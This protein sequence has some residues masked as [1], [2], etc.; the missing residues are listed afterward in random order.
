MITTNKTPLYNIPWAEPS[1]MV[2]CTTTSSDAPL[3]ISTLPDNVLSLSATE[4]C[5]SD[6]DTLIS[7]DRDKLKLI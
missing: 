6:N 5:G 3:F 1:L 4:Y 2:T 7:T